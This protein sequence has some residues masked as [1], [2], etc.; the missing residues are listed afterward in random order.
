MTPDESENEVC[1]TLESRLDRLW[2]DQQIFSATDDR[3][4]QLGDY[5]IQRAVGAG[6][7]GIVY[8]ATDTKSNNPVALKVPRSEVLVERRKLL[9]FAAEASLI[10][11]LNH[12]NIVKFHQ[13]D[14]ESPVP[15]LATEWCDGSDLAAWMQR[16]RSDI[17]SPAAWKRAAKLVLEIADAVEHVHQ[18]GIAHR[19]LKP[20]NIMLCRRDDSESDSLSN[21]TPKVTDFGLGKIFDR[22]MVITNSSMLVGTPIYMAPELLDSWRTKEV[23]D[24]ESSFAADVY[25][26]GAIL[27]ELLAGR[28]LVNGYSFHEVLDDIRNGRTSSLTSLR[29]DLPASI[30]KIVA[31]CLQLNPKARYASAGNLVQDLKRCLAGESIE[32][33]PISITSQYQFWHSRQSWP[34]TAGRFAIAGGGLITAWVVVTTVAAITSG[35]VPSEAFA[36]TAM[37]SFALMFTLTLPLMF[38]GWMCI[39]RKRLASLIGTVFV[40][41]H[42]I[43]TGF[44]MFGNPVAF[45]ALHDSQDYFFCLTVHLFF[46]LYFFV[47]AILFI[48][49][50]TSS[51]TIR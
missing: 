13:A 49:A 17:Y 27:F 40:L 32:G 38:I 11:E 9:H 29:P 23:C 6:A 39:A 45:K 18:K 30:C 47:Q 14:T 42:L 44:G 10:S 50:W 8:L 48:A 34:Q 2:D 7:F 33:Q 46:F 51:K 16:P 41:G 31:T 15:W 26:L 19:D 24:R 22:D 12:P 25:S 4:Q 1:D 20:A 28:P 3:D 37:D 35:A 43:S 36:V 5:K 21:F